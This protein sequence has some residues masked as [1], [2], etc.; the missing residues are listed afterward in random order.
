MGL[1]ELKTQR[2]RAAIAAAALEL[3]ERQGYE[4]TTMEQIAAAAEVAPTTLYRYFPT[5]ESTLLDELLP[6]AVSLASL[7]R[8]RPA[9]EDLPHALGHALQTRLAST[10]E[11]AEH[12][13]RLRA[14][15]DIIPTVRAQMWDITYQELADL[16][17]AI[18]E[19]SGADPN[20]LQVQITAHTV[21]TVFQM[22]VDSMR[23]TPA[24]VSS[25]AHA[26]AVLAAMRHGPLA[27]PEF[28]D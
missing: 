17:E 26:Q 27:L 8:S 7:L 3:F 18:A 14:Q 16:Q 10:D 22:A 9:S 1:R 13:L 23:A 2:T 4:T 24:S 20:D 25:R 11:N 12:V 15:I 28:S 5:K 6:D 21:L 19:R